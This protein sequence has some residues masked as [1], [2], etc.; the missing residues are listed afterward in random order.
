MYSNE[1]AEQQ[2][3]SLTLYGYT[4]LCSLSLLW[5][6]RSR[7][8]HVMY[9][10]R[11]KKTG[12]EVERLD[13]PLTLPAAGF[14][15]LDLDQSLLRATRVLLNVLHDVLLL[16]HDD[17]S[18]ISDAPCAATLACR[19]PPLLKKLRGST[20]LTYVIHSIWVGWNSQA[21]PMQTFFSQRNF[22][23]CVIGRRATYSCVYTRFEYCERNSNYIYRKRIPQARYP[24]PSCL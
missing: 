3:W 23:H 22:R 2:W 18:F 10:I 11:S 4:Y 9:C 19:K 24:L 1:V 5:S 6:L 15:I 16:T 20:L 13:A 8:L 21:Q 7:E 14:R 17:L 12:S